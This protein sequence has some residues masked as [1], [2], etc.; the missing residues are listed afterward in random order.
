MNFWGRS[1]FVDIFHQ[2]CLVHKTVAGSVV[3]N[4]K[5]C[6]ICASKHR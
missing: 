4:T 2:V 3:E 6:F 1:A 5:V